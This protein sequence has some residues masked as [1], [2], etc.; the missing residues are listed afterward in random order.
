[1]RAS[2]IKPI[3]YMKTHSAQLV[4]G[5]NQSRSPVVI[6]QNGEARAVV[7][8][9]KSYERMQDALILLKLI[10]QSE[11]DF[12]RGRWKSQKAVEASLLRKFRT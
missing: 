6:T 10:S 4:A 5:V 1:M 8:D 9:I 7:V 11:E 12:R 3:T 2:A